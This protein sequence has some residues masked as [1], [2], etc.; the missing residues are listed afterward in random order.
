MLSNS[1]A[2]HQRDVKGNICGVSVCH[3]LN[4]KG[5]ERLLPWVVTGLL[6]WAW[7]PME[8]IPAP[9][10]RWYLVANPWFFFIEG[11]IRAGARGHWVSPHHWFP[12]SWL[13]MDICAVSDGYWTVC[14]SSLSSS[15]SFFHLIIDQAFINYLFWQSWPLAL[16]WKTLKSCSVLPHKLTSMQDKYYGKDK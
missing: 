9:L 10:C 14:K 7:C 1:E 5:W 2:F 13:E 6:L 12:K 15:H 11:W 3:T 4:T 8:G 16:R